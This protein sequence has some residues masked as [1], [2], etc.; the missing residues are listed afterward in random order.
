MCTQISIDIWCA[1]TVCFHRL[2]VY[3]RVRLCSVS[4]EVNMLPSWGRLSV[5]GQPQ[6]ESPVLNSIHQLP[7]WQLHTV[8]SQ[9][10]VISCFQKAFRRWRD[11]LEVS[12]PRQMYWTLLNFP[13]QTD[14]MHQNVF[15]YIHIDDRQEFRRQLH[16]AMCPPEGASA[17]QDQ[18]PAGTGG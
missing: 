14:V 5:S 11:E 16:W 17:H 13:R 7:W 18:P 2:W 15:D 1:C 10:A 8:Q 3:S 9:S 6:Q 4:G 12:F